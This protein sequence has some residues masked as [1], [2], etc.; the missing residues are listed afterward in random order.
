MEKE[1]EKEHEVTTHHKI[2]VIC[3]SMVDIHVDT[4]QIFNR[5]NIS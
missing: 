3:E 4:I 2:T 1:L 5:E